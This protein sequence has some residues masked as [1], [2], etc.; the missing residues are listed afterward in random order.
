MVDRGAARRR[1]LQEMSRS[2]PFS[3]PADEDLPE[4]LIDPSRDNRDGMPN[5]VF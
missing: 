5:F 1:Y 4:E 2:D 3:G